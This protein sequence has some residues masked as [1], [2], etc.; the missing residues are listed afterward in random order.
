MA[1]FSGANTKISVKN[2][3]LIGNYL[4]N[5]VEECSG[6][7]FV[8]NNSQQPIYGYASVHY[9][10][11]L[12]GR[13]IIQGNMLINFTKNNY[14]LDIID[15]EL[16]NAAA[17]VSYSQFFSPMFDI[18]IEFLRNMGNN[19]YIILENCSIISVGTTAQISDQPIME[20]YS[21]IGRNL[22]IVEQY[23]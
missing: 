17:Q 10:A 3:S 6:I 21:F 9:D 12:P 13:E 18:K 16:A 2:K 20:E 11:M 19:E 7:S 1:Y 15:S 23:N 22:S 4:F 8:L 5:H 14:L